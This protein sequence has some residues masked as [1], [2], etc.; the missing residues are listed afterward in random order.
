MGR[1]TEV[2]LWPLFLDTKRG[3]ICSCYV[4][5]SGLLPEKLPIRF[6][7]IDLAPRSRARLCF[8]RTV[9]ESGKVLTGRRVWLVRRDSKD[10]RLWK[11]MKLWQGLLP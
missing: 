5:Q 9:W 10:N 3:G 2:V 8:T 1:A 6:M 11:R 7:E 4:G